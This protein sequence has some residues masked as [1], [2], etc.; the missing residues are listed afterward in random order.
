VVDLEDVRSFRG[1]MRSR[2]EQ[3]ARAPAYPRV[4]ADISLSSGSHMFDLKLRPTRVIE[5]YFMTPEQEI[6]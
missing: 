1:A 4:F 3:A 5:P 2:C 6:R